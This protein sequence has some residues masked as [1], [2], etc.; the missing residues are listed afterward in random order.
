MH[1]NVCLRKKKEERHSHNKGKLN[2]IKKRLYAE[3]HAHG[4][5]VCVLSPHLFESALCHILSPKPGS[6]SWRSAPELTLRLE[7]NDGVKAE[8]ERGMRRIVNVRNAQ[9]QRWEVE[10]GKTKRRCWWLLISL[11]GSNKNHLWSSSSF[12]DFYSVSCHSMSI[13]GNAPCVLEKTPFW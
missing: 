1:S 11:S 8:G 13:T 7:I 3:A 6:R 10:L 4:D 2:G 12:Y 9:W 5:S